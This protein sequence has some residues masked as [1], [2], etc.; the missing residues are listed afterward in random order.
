M[1][2]NTIAKKQDNLWLSLYEKNVFSQNG[3][4]GILEKIFQVLRVE[5]GL[6]V[7]FGAWNGKH[8]S[9]T[10]DLIENKRWSAILIEADKTKFKELADNFCGNNKVTCINSLVGFDN[11]NNIEQILRKKSVPINFDFISIDIDGNDYYIWESMKEYR[12]KVVAIEFNPTIPPNVEYAQKKDMSVSQ[13]SSLKSMYLLGK[14]KGY[15]LIATTL[16]NALFVDEKYF[17]LFDIKNNT[18][19]VLQSHKDYLTG[20]F[21]L[22]DGTLMLYGYDKLLWHNKIKIRD[23]DIQILPRFFRKFP[24]FMNPTTSFFFKLWRK[25]I[26]IFEKV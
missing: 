12:P 16:V 13:G 18:P 1:E 19:E 21:Q 25:M 10:Y 4:D 9:N 2:Q 11:D 20:I 8:L 15:E 5:K 23:K 22:Y 3:E 6:C 7:E 14:N 24:G 26:K 17:N